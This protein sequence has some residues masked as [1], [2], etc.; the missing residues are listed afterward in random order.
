MHNLLAEKKNNEVPVGGCCPFTRL[1][2]VTQPGQQQKK[3]TNVQILSADRGPEIYCSC[4][5]SR[6][7]QPCRSGNFVLKEK[8]KNI[9]R[10]P[11]SNCTFSWKVEDMATWHRNCSH[12]GLAAKHAF[13]LWLAR[14]LS[15]ALWITLT[16]SRF[17]FYNLNDKSKCSMNSW[18]KVRNAVWE[19]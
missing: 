4:V 5:I 18:N 2:P 7:G 9:Y 16:I 12:P 15:M 6:I 3:P 19:Q 11:T 14:T 10:R 13:F 8:R 17:F 1:P